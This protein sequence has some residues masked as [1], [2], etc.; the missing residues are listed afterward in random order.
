MYQKDRKISFFSSFCFVSVLNILYMIFNSSVADPDVYTG[1]PIL[2]LS[3][4]DPR[5]T[6][7]KGVGSVVLPFFGATNIIKLKLFCF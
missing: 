3:I 2:I 1:S 6:E 4:P 5:S 7:A